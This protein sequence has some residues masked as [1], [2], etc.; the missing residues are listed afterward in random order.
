M[1]SESPNS[2]GF[3]RGKLLPPFL[4]ALRRGARALQ[5]AI[6][7]AVLY[8][9]ALVFTPIGDWLGKSLT[10][11]DPLEQADYIVVLGGD[12]ERGVEA[13]ELYRQGYAP[14]VVFSSRPE[15]VEHDAQV[16]R[17]YGLPAE[18]II[19]DPSP[20]RTA[21][22]P[23]TIGTLPGIDPKNTRLI[24]VTSLYHTSRAK[25]V[26]D[27]AGYAHTCMR[28]PLWR[29]YEQQHI[30]PGWSGRSRDLV[31]KLYETLA[32]AMYKTRGWA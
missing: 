21:D 5:W 31:G 3:L 11:V 29:I 19:L 8:C 30:R 26:F 10:H 12:I 22:H 14:K 18:A 9:L 6:Y 7:L 15:G 20:A 32:W 13:A 4:R 28:A 17:L 23:Q 1:V 25:A 27:K 16:A 24:L 2:V